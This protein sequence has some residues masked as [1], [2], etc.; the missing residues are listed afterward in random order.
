MFKRILVGYDGSEPA[1][2]S[3]L[4]AFELASCANGKVTFLAVVRP[5]EFVEF[6]VKS[7]LEDAERRLAD[8]FRWAE[9]EAQKN[10]IS[11]E[12]RTELGH[13]AE[14][15]VKVAEDEKYDLIIIGRRGITKAKRWM[16]GSISERVL[17]YAPCPVMVLH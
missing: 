6:E 3:L 5:P 16:L 13:P 9:E 2:K 8:A 11:L 7:F 4:A 17:R 12:I 14:V 15:L 10:S 1:R